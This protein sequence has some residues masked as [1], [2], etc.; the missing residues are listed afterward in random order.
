MSDDFKGFVFVVVTLII[1]LGAPFLLAYRIN[2][3]W[4]NELI[5]RG[6]GEWCVDP[7][8]GETSFIYI[9]GHEPLAEKE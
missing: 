8:T 2:E 6:I 5:S 1:V 3:N 9:L 4:H 7:K